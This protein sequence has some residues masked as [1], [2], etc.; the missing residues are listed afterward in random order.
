VYEVVNSMCVC[1]SLGEWMIL[2]WGHNHYKC[3]A[4]SRWNPWFDYMEGV[5]FL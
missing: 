5:F 4:V 3:S 2:C 1:V